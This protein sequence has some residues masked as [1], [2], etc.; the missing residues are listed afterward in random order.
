MPLTITWDTVCA[1]AAELTTLSAAA[2]TAVLDQ[3]AA[4]V[5]VAK[6]PSQAKADLA[7][8]WLARHLGTLAKQ[9]GGTAALQSVSV[10][11]VSKTF[12]TS[13]AMDASSLQ[14]T[15]YGTEYLRLR[16]A[17]LPRSAVT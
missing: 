15:R 14:Q 1:L 9:G 2:Q 5:V 11:G 4:E 3:V 17:W 12:A 10:G 8:S 6:W 16:R 7:A 13:V